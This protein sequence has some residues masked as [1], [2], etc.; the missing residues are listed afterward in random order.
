MET[1][2]NIDLSPLL[3]DILTK[4]PLISEEEEPL[5]F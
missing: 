4:M 5:T 1:L 3:T 2:K